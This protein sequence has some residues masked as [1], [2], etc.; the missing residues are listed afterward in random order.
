MPTLTEPRPVRRVPVSL[1]PAAAR[2]PSAP[3]PLPRS[4]RFDPML[5]EST[6]QGRRRKKILVI[7]SVV[8]HAILFTILLLLPGTDPTIADPTL[9]IQIVFQTPTPPIEEHFAPPPPAPKP[10]PELKAKPLPPAPQPRVEAPPPPKV[11]A[12]PPPPAA[13][14]P[15]PVVKEPP[16]PRPAVRIG[17]LGDANEAPIVAKRIPQAIPSSSGFDDAGPAVGAGAVRGARSV[18][19]TSFGEAGGTGPADH[20]AA[21]PGK[22]VASSFDAAPAKEA[23]RPASAPKR[24][25]EGPETDVEILSKAKPV[26]T[27][28]ARRSKIEGDVVLEVTFLASGTLRVLR[29]I[30]GLGYGLDEAAVA[31]AKKIQF[32]PA[33]R[34]GQPVDHTA[35]LRVV[36][37]LA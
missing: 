29:V 7:V 28:E 18:V 16:A 22:V 20:R 21:R 10:K 17:M 31:A 34:N 19:G 4:V 35:T 12:A 23:A 3:R 11:E 2:P 5:T 37:R 8:S 33:K 14:Q 1:S 36:F 25:D 27:E 24:A 13:E 15:K 32:T 6:P 30:E 9:P 26:Y